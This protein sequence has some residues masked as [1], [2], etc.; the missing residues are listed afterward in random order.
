[1]AL[2]NALSPH[3]PIG[4]TSSDRRGHS[5][6]RCHFELAARPEA[7]GH[8]R[9]L[10][11]DQLA[12]WTLDEEI[13]DSASLVVSELV[14][15]AVVHTVSDWIMCELHDAPAKDQLRIVVRDEGCG[16]AGPA[17]HPAR[18][19]DEDHGRGL[20]LVSA[21]SRAWGAKEVGLGLLVWAE[22]PRE[23]GAACA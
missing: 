21:M 23:A 20:L 22:L 8:A 4:A 3:H 2:G 15:N 7:V 6:R 19:A 17:P 13:L 11:R 9:R 10:T 5:D 1:M 16:Q 12:A 18:D 14:T